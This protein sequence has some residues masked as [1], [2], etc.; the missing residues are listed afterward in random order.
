[1]PLCLFPRKKKNMAQPI[2]KDYFVDF[3]AI[4]SADFSISVDGT[5]IFEGRAVKKPSQSTLQVKIND[6]CQ[7]YLSA[8][9]PVFTQGVFTRDSIAKTFEV[10]KNGTLVQSV[11]FSLDYSYDYNRSNNIASSPII[12]K[13]V[14]DQPFIFSQY[15]AAQIDVAITTPTGVIDIPIAIA[16]QDDFNDDF[17]MDFAQSVAKAASGSIYIDLTKYGNPSKVQVGGITY[18]VVNTC[19]RFA[20]YY[21]NAYGG[22][23][24]LLLQGRADEKDVITRKEVTLTYDNRTPQARGRQNYLNEVVKTYTLRTGWLTD[25]QAA[26]MWHLLESTNV[27]LYD[28]VKKQMHSCIITNAEAPFKTFKGE[29]GKLV[30]YELN[31]ELSQGRVRR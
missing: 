31:V 9:L 22:W 23:D 15:E 12:P 20:L 8:S 25:A 21:V 27:Y 4:T 17:N 18:D 2:W 3:G 1:M 14:A 13:V 24:S 11:T 30:S 28:I 19:D 26:K 7:A 10:Y 29:G 16:K 6:I 5:I